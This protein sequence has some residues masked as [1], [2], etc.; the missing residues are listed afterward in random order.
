LRGSRLDI[1]GYTTERKMER[2]LIADYRFS[3]EDALVRLSAA[4]YEYVVE[5]AS[6]PEKIRGFGYIKERNALAAGAR[7]RTLEQALQQ[8]FTDVS[9]GVATDNSTN[10]EHIGAF[11][12]DTAG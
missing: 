12:R 5:L 2:Q 7:W 11:R 10:E 6:L 9:T 8:N 1:F 3:I 4:N